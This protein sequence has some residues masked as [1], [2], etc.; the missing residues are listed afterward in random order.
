MPVV[1]LIM[2]DTSNSFLSH[3]SIVVVKVPF[4]IIKLEMYC[5][6]LRNVVLNVKLN[7]IVGDFG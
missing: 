2:K 1:A 5:M 4:I 7:T 6:S 3:H